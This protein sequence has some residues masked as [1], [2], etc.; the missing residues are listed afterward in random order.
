[1]CRKSSLLNWMRSPYRMRV[2]SYFCELDVLFDLLLTER[3][4]E[5]VFVAPLKVGGSKCMHRCI[6]TD[7]QV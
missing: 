1:M 3:E 5:A 2:R 4:S 7:I 6:N